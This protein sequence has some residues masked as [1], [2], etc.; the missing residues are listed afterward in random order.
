MYEVVVES[1]E[2]VGGM[3]TE[4]EPLWCDFIICETY[5]MTNEVLVVSHGTYIR[6][7]R[8]E[9]PDETTEPF[10]IIA[11]ALANTSRI[12]IKEGAASS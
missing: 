2:F 5:D 7:T 9:E 4:C 10:E 1:S 11:Y 3:N 8:G 12:R 6:V